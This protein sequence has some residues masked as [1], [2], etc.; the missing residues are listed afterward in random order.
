MTTHER[1]QAAADWLNAGNRWRVRDGVA[2]WIGFRGIGRWTKEL[3]VP[4]GY[5]GG[6][7]FATNAQILKLARSEGWQENHPQNVPQTG[8]ETGQGEGG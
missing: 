1:A 7:D 3:I 4:D 2:D 8:A 5:V 6:I